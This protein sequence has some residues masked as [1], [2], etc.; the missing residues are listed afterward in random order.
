MNTK[1]IILSGILAFACITPA[2]AQVEFLNS[3]KVVKGDLPFSEAVKK[4]QAL[5]LSGQVGLDP[6]S[7]KLV[8]GGIGS[9]TRQTMENIKAVLTA[10]GYALTD[11]IKCTVFLV[12]MA[13]FPEFNGVYARFFQK[14]SY[15]TRSTVA[16]S[17]LAMGAKV[18]VE[19][20]ASK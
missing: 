18:E 11:V 9:E 5:Y 12:D 8:A 10:H 13:D 15:P 14:G 17:G 19:C 1:A 4:G 20:M 6:A 16:V 3:G 7:Q 2:I